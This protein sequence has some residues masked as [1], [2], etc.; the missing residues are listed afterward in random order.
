MQKRTTT[1]Q[2]WNWL[3]GRKRGDLHSECVCVCIGREWRWNSKRS[4]SVTNSHEITF[5]VWCA[6]RSN[7][8]QFISSHL[9]R[10]HRLLSTEHAKYFVI[11]E[12]SWSLPF[13]VDECVIAHLRHNSALA[14][15]GPSQQ[16]PRNEWNTSVDC[17]NVT[18]FLLS[19][20]LS[21]LYFESPPPPSAPLSNRICFAFTWCECIAFSL[22]GRGGGSTCNFIILI[23][24]P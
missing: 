23:Y 15:E 21:E 6:F 1:N 20:R 12:E 3:N 14:N 17:R 5:L 8:M 11:N 16:P 13:A 4:V 24:D 22:G 10:A 9:H 7:W 2:R 19:Q 18:L